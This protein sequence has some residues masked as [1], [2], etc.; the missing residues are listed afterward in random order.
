MKSAYFSL[1]IV[2]HTKTCLRPQDTSIK[3]N[4][5]GLSVTTGTLL[6]F[7]VAVLWSEKCLHQENVI[8]HKV[9]IAYSPFITAVNWT[10]AV[11]YWHKDSH[12]VYY[13]IFFICC[14]NVI[15]TS[16]WMKIARSRLKIWKQLG[17]FSWNHDEESQQRSILLKRNK[18]QKQP[19]WHGTRMITAACLNIYRT[20]VL[21][22]LR[23][24][25][26]KTP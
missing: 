4:L 15:M 22:S 18:A 2:K 5:S 10:T 11:A 17:I 6:I 23:M 9:C 14:V 12:R 26:L 21:S 3:F 7:S 1:Y 19:L 24:N 16:S 8:T 25:G 13:I 20:V